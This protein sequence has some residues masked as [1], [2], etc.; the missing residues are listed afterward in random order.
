[1]KKIYNS[2]GWLFCEIAFQLYKISPDTDGR[3]ARFVDDTIYYLFYKPGSW[4][5]NKG[6]DS[7]SP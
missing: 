5:Y 2:L 6:Y 7:N 1:M 3:I 4:F